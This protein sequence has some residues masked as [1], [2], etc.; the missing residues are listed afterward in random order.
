MSNPAQQQGGGA[1]HRRLGFRSLATLISSVAVLAA[2]LG[3]TSLAGAAPAAAA[4]PTSIQ[5][6]GIHKIR[7]IVI[8]VQENRSFDSYFGT[9]PGALGIPMKNGVPTVCI[10]DPRLGHCVRPYPDHHD[11]NGGAQHVAYSARTAENHGKMNGFIRVA[12]DRPRGCLGDAPVCRTSAPP[13]VMGYHTQSDIPNYWAYAKH[14]VLQDHFFSGVNSWS[15]PSH[16]YIFS[17]WSAICSDPEDPATCKSSLMPKVQSKQDPTPYG[18]T[19]LTYLLD[20]HHVNWTVYLDGGAQPLSGSGHHR[21]L[22]SK[23]LGT[24]GLKTKKKAGNQPGV[25]RIWNV[26][27]G[28][29]DVHQ[30]HQLGHLQDLKNFFKNAK[31]GTLPAVSWIL[32]DDRQ[33]EHP[34][35]LVS[36]GQSYVTNLINHVMESPDWSSTAIFLTWDDWGGFYDNVAPPKVDALGFGLRVPGL[37]ISPY[38]KKGY[39]DNQILSTDAYLKFIED[40]FLGGQT[41]NPLTDGRWD[42]RPD[43]RETDPILGNLVKDFNFHQKPR[44]PFILPV[45]PKTTLIRPK[46]PPKLG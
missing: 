12:E 25:P 45:H 16:L 43:V 37:V 28:F 41:L 44:P 2:A 8:I 3:M 6:T 24:I 7:H 36:V 27:P 29:V 46:V 35:A 9:Y 26:L 33:S 19:D 23:V 18:W 11:E 5:Q 10:P 4:R 13:D 14:F 38:A 22:L 31:D 1:G 17:G 42:P 21:S 15:L 32:P 34:P 20:H 30:D 40:D 39:I